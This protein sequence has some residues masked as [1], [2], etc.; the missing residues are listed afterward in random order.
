MSAFRCAACGAMNRVRLPPPAPPVCGRC[1]RDLDLSGAPQPLDAGQLDA[2]VRSAPVP[3]LVDF[4]APWC[5][6]CRAAAPILEQLAQRRAGRLLVGKVN[7]DDA[8]S[9][10]ARHGIQAIPTFILFS[11]GR[12]LARHSGVLA[13]PELE[14][15]LERAGAGAA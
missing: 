11:E 9:A 14:R 6:P 7:S 13:L 8:A 2:A 15:W 12:E 1:K 5:G 4:W 3:L 10:A